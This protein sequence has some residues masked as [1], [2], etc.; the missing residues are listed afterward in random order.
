MSIQVTESAANAIKKQLE[1][2]NTP[3]ASIRFGIRGGGCTGYAY[4][5]EFTDNPP[6]D[7][8]SALDFHGITVIIDAKSMLLLNGTEIDFENGMRG[9]GFKFS[10]PNVINS[11]GC[12]ESVNF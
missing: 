3:D 6:R 7:S 11:C 10:N 12:G 1:K 5:F 2:R 4:V 9:H 8:D